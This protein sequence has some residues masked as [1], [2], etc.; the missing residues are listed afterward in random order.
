MCGRYTLLSSPKA[1]QEHFALDKAPDLGPRY[2]IAPTQQVAAIRRPDPTSPREL[3]RLRWG[4]VPSWADDLSIGN[5]LINARAETVA[6]KP[7]FRSAFRSRRCLVVADG[8]YEWQRQ[9]KNKQPFYFCLRD[10]KPFAFAGLWERWSRDDQVVESCTLITTE[11]NERVQAVHDRMPVILPA[12]A[13]DAWLDPS[14]TRPLELTHLLRPYPAG[15][16]VAHAVGARVNSPY[17]DDPTCI[18]RVA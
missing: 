18:E 1:I 17:N 8:F 9:G 12:I 3:V 14:A 5:R 16:L 13:Y 6:G 10:G 7:S 2:N 15:E 11:A 4:L